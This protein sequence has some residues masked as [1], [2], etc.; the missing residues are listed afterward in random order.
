MVRSKNPSYF[1]LV[2]PRGKLGNV[3]SVVATPAVPIP[4][5][6]VALWMCD[7]V[8]GAA[9]SLNDTCTRIVCATISKSTS[10]D[11]L[12]G[13]APPVISMGPLRLAKYIIGAG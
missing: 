9:K 12:P 6:A 13:D 10:A 4:G 8:V 11:P 5:T 3:G 7:A 2:T 1:P